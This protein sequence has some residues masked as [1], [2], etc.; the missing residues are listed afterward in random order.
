LDKPVRLFVGVL[1]L[2]FAIVALRN[3]W[4]CDDAYISFRTVDNFINGHGLV[5]NTG[6]RVQGFTHPLWVFLAS[7]VY[8][9][10]NEIYFT[11]IFLSL[12]L[13]IGSL[14][15]LAFKIGRS[16]YG[17]LLSITI[18]ICSKAYVDYTTSGLENAL[19]YFIM[20]V[21]FSLFVK[22]ERSL[23][24]F[25]RLSLLAAL[26]FLNR[27]D[28]VLLYAPALL[29]FYWGLPRHAGFKRIVLGFLPVI[30]W[31]LF[32]LWYYGWPFPNTYYAKLHA[33]IPSGEL[34]IQGLIYYLDSLR[35]DPLTLVVI[36]ASFLVAW[37]SREP[38]SLAISVGILLYLLY[39]ITI[40][41]DF[42]S[43]RFFAA[44]LLASAIIIS[45]F[46]WNLPPSLVVA[47]IAIVVILGLVSPR[48]PIKS[49]SNFGIGPERLIPETGV[50][51]ER[52]HYYQQTGL[53]LAK[54]GEEM[55][56][57]K[58]CEDGRDLKRDGTPFVKAGC[59]GFRG[60][61]AGP[62]IHITD[63]VALTDPLLSHLPAYRARDWRIGHLS[64]AFPGGYFESVRS[65]ENRIADS[66]LAVYYDKLVVLFRGDLLSFS[67][68]IEIIKMNLGFYDHLLD[69]YVNDQL[70]V[71]YDDIS[72]PRREGTA[73]S[74]KGNLI[75]NRG[76]MTV[77]L[78]ERSYKSLIE[79]S[80]DNND[81]YEIVF[82]SNS[83]KLGF[84][85]TGEEPTP[86]LRLCKLNI[87]T[88]AVKTGFNRIVIK[89]LFGDGYY[90]V[91]HVRLL[92]EPN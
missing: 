55:P 69:N 65:G 2:I 89:P 44:P 61:Y 90:S 85:E 26:G 86:G 21:F 31:E 36:G 91:G 15:V 76:G 43:G 5:W 11:S 62:E 30:A 84:V 48:S 1:I 18:C 34:M 49:D 67:R 32:S 88:A 73:W 7:A 78:E 47:P 63:G 40:G 77:T 12:C 68:I 24:A 6:E 53:L 14:L 25:F 41:G 72:E 64:R 66:S 51:D 10:T 81:T 56:R 27:M 52:G 13:A 54:R 74:D 22:R 60:F 33:G 4:V 58:W 8:F 38:R 42:M 29:Y 71:S 87:P 39:T 19:T 70:I 23:D 28:T 45:R 17:V 80:V 35:I 3:A 16:G 57:H 82:Y 20:A 79:V 9:V 75:L 83:E 46:N 37:S 50:A 92:D 59:I